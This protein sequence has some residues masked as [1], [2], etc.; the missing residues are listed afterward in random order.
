MT[1]SLLHNVRALRPGVG[2][3]GSAVLV[4]DGRI[5]AIDP[6]ADLLPSDLNRVD[7]GG[8]LL[9]PGLIDLHIHGLGLY[10]FEDSPEAMQAGLAELPRYGVTRVL[11]TL[12][13]VMNKA[14]LPKLAKL[15]AALKDVTAVRV[16]GFH[17]EGPF[18]ALPGAGS[19]TVPGDLALLDALFEATDGCIT[20]M[21]VSPDT[22]DVIPVIERLAEHGVAVF[23]THTRANVEQSEAAIEAGAR[24]ATHFYDVFPVPDATEPG[25]R[26]TGVVEAVLAD[27]RVSVDFILDGVHV[28]PVAVRAALAAKGPRRTALITDGNI[29]AGLPVGSR[30]K[31]WELEVRVAEDGAARIHAPGTPKHGALAGSALTMNRA[32]NHA[33]QWLGLPEQDAWAM[34]TLAPGRLLNGEMIGDLVAGAD[35][36]LVLWDEPEG[37]LVAR[38]TWVAGRLVYNTSDTM[39]MSH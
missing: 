20:A 14:S 28:P 4:E 8:R 34:A 6:P 3:V 29:G 22:L 39:E 38:Q 16:P 13:R 11:P 9:T 36:D 10:L 33:R 1:A 31:A 35:A 19:E 7:G 5:V 24:H 30:H 26:P 37:E 18:L 21:S 17:L 25:V 15:T 2:V 23:L 12:Y 32:V 27:E